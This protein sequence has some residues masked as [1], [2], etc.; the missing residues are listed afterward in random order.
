MKRSLKRRRSLKKSRKR[1][2][3][4]RTALSKKIKINIG[5]FKSGRYKSK[6]QAIAVSYSQVSK[7]YPRCK[8]Y[9]QKRSR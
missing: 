2:S 5:E 6:A 7:K 8:R 3:K 1:K 9:L 4:C